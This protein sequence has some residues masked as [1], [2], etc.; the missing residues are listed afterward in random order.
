MQNNIIVAKFG[1]SSLADAL[2]FEKVKAIIT[3]DTNRKYII[4]SAPGKR[5]K[6][7]IKITDM[8]IECYN[9]KN[10]FPQIKNRYDEIISDLGLNISLS[11]EYSEIEKHISDN[12]EYNYI[13]SRGEY[14]CGIILAAYLGFEFIDSAE[15]IKFNNNGTYDS[16]LT[17]ELLRKKLNNNAV[18]PGFYGSDNIGNIKTFSRSGSD[19]TGAIVA[20]AVGAKTYENWTDVPGVMVADPRVVESPK[21]IE[22]I[23]YR[24]LRELAYMGANVLHE[25]AIFP[26][27]SAMIPINIKDTNNPNLPG[28]MIIP[29]ESLNGDDDDIPTS[30]Y[31]ITGIAGKRGFRTLNIEK[32][33]LNSE[34]GFCRKVLQVFEDNGISIEHIPTGIDTISVIYEDKFDGETNYKL[35]NEISVAVKPS[36][37]SYEKDL[38]LLAV[39][40]RN[41][42]NTRGIAAKIFTAL[43]NAGINIKMLDQGSSEINII[44]SVLE[45]DLNNAI[46]VIYKKFIK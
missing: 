9:G 7:D 26:V 11:E 2:Q 32:H 33:M 44:I 43:E 25:D 15:V 18:I 27:R 40:G 3:K 1:G 24:E 12:P 16:E 23:T 20:G 28:T 37:M 41:M 31:L 14:L 46:R 19:V 30:E 35:M 45:K 4:P 36:R 39:V 17:N 13:I 29:S 42:R 10:L 5:F 22:T 8:L 34:I 6:Q 21:V 38:A